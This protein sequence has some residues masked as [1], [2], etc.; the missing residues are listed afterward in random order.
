MDDKIKEPEDIFLTEE[1]KSLP[2]LKR[3]WIRLK[4]AFFVTITMI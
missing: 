2:F 1:F 3:V 4:V